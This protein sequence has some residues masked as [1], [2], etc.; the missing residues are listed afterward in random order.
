MEQAFSLTEG[1]SW[2]RG[3]WTLRRQ[4]VKILSAVALSRLSTECTKELMSVWTLL[5][6]L[7][8]SLMSR[9]CRF[10]TTRLVTWSTSGPIAGPIAGA[11]RWS[12]LRSTAMAVFCAILTAEVMA[13][14]C[15]SAPRILLV[16]VLWQT[17]SASMQ[18]TRASYTA[19]WAKSPL[20]ILVRRHEPM[21][22]RFEII[23]GDSKLRRARKRRCLWRRNGIS[24]EKATAIA[25]ERSEARRGR[26]P[27]SRC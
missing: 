26:C 8:L 13:L 10:C 21:V 3:S 12:H 24:D 27:R 14:F 2:R 9:S 1:E 11:H 5:L 7:E 4:T 20:R 19:S 6:P 16:R 15:F 17:L 25:N 23:R 18:K 22:T